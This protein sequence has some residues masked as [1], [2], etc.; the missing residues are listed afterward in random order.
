[1]TR[2][3]GAREAC[4]LLGGLLLDGASAALL[5]ELARDGLARRLG[6][7]L[8]GAI[9]GP[10][11]GMDRALADEGTAAVSAEYTRLTAADAGARRP[12]PVP[13]W[14]D[15]HL[16]ADRRVMGERSR[17]VLQAYAAAGLGFDGMKEVPADHIGLELL[18]VAT[19]LDEEI[20]LGRDAAARRGF[21]AA[22]LA[23]FA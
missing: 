22:H 7:E 17:A 4:R 11:A 1:M 6:Q 20:R 13:L 16:G 12:V 10:F 19:L 21:V 15:V 2:T 14:E 3:E 5:A 18:F 8:G 23:P 9:A